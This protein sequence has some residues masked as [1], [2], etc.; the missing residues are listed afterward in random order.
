MQ[1]RS[2]Y[3]LVGHISHNEASLPGHVSFKASLNTLYMDN[4]IDILRE[5]SCPLRYYTVSMGL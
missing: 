1:W 5:D 2:V 4:F 3:A